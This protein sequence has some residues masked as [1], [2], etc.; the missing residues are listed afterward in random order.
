MNETNV[1][2]HLAKKKTMKHLKQIF[3]IIEDYYLLF[4]SKLIK[5]DPRGWARQIT[6]AALHFNPN[7]R[8]YLTKYLFV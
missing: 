3:V 1:Q 7:E 4:F 5:G 8:S 6:L 2:G